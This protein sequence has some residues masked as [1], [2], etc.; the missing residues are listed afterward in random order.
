MN[1][2]QGFFPPRPRRMAGLGFAA[3]AA[4]MGAAS[5]AQAFEDRDAGIYI[6]AGQAP[7]S[8]GSTDVLSAGA[9]IPWTPRR[10]VGS[11]SLSFYWDLFVSHWRA[12]ADS[13]RRDYAQLG[14]IG[15]WRLRFD[16]GRS[17]WFVEAGVGGS[18]LDHLYHTPSRDF[19]TAFQFTE[20]LGAG[21]SFGERGQ[22]ELSLRL[23]HFSNADIKRPNQGENFVRLRYAYRF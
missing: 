5:P 3:L 1:H 18:A 21:Y 23:Q 4:L 11:G 19:S 12:P 9:M 7:H 6:E 13:L 22:H 2:R 10:L 8:A 17:P 16:Q 14:A 20:A 15:T